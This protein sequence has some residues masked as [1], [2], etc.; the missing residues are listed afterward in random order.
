MKSNEIQRNVFKQD[1]TRL[2][3]I[4]LKKMKLNFYLYIVT[5]V[6]T[7][8]VRVDHINGSVFQSS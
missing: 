5:D 8:Q 3:S 4:I 6:C 7:G 1:H 2:N